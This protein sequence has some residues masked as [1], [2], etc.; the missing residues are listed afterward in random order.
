MTE[1]Q[2]DIVNFLES[3]VH[4]RFSEEN[5]NKVLSEKFGE[6]IIV[7]DVSSL[8][9]DDGLADYNLMFNSEKEDTYGYFD[10]YMLPM[11]CT[12]FD[13][14]TMYITEIGYEFE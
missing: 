8:R 12:G 14:A 7:E 1:K 10:I 6:E 13:G 5:L 11:R 2:K 3:L 4:K 9:N